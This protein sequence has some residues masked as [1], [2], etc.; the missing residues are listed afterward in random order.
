MNMSEKPSLEE[1]LKQQEDFYANHVKYH[2]ANAF[3]GTAG[4]E[5]MKHIGSLVG[6]M[7]DEEVSELVKEAGI[8]VGNGNS[9]DRD[10]YEG[11]IDEMDR[12][13][14][15]RIYAE[16]LAKRSNPSSTKSSPLPDRPK[17]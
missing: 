8:N 7:T 17:A 10:E 11:M 2:P 14:F 12:E 3:C 15:Y 6:G 4:S 5:E 9:I 16:L 13:D 1:Y